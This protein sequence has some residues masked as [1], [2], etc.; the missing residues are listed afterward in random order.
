MLVR[1]SQRHVF[2]PRRGQPPVCELDLVARRP[3]YRDYAISP[4]LFHWETQSTTSEDSPT[5]RRYQ[6]HRQEGSSVMLFVGVRDTEV[7]GPAFSGQSTQSYLGGTVRK[8]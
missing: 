4:E 6:R 1:R 5:G 3:R 2:P 8:E 7:R